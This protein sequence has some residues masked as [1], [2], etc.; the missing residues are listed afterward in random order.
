V[1]AAIIYLTPDAPL[2]TGT[3]FFTHDNG[4]S[5]RTEMQH[6]L[7][8]NTEQERIEKGINNVLDDSHNNTKWTL[9]SS[10]GNVYNRLVIYKSSQIH[11]SLDYFGYDIHD[12]RLMQIIFF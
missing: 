4:I 3:G 7:D 6:Y 10:V 2:G 5:D 11:K 12:S 9:N 8:N 1:Y